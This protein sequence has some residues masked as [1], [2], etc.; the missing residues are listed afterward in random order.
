MSS[1]AA[2]KLTIDVSPDFR[3]ALEIQASTHGKT[4][5][6]YVL[7]ALTDRVR[8]HSV[9]EDKTWGEMSEIAKA[10]KILSYEDSEDLLNRMKNA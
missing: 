2:T 4:L 8:R 6:N 9:E 5:K 7:D 1:K 3:D 10:E